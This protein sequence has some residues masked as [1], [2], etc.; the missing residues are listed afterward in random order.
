MPAHDRVT[1]K[2]ATLTHRRVL[3]F[4]LPITLSNVTVPLL[5]LVDTGVIGQLG[6]AAPIGAVGIG[7]AILS[8][9]FWVFGFLRMGT[10]G[11][12]AQAHGAGDMAEV[13]AMLTRGLLVA[14]VAGAALIVLQVPLIWAAFQIA[15][16]SDE[17]EG[18]ARSYLQIRIFGAPVAIGIYAMTGWLIALERTRAVLA[19]QLMTNTV[20][21][22][23]DLW[24][25]LGMDWGIEGVA[26][27]TLMAE[28]L[29]FA[30]GLFLCREV[31]A[32]PGWADPRRI[33][34]TVVLKHM[35]AVN[36]DILIRSLLLQ[37]IFI[38]FMFFGAKLSDVELAANQVLIQFVYVTAYALDGFALAAE[39]FVGQ[40]VGRRQVHVLRRASVMTSWW[41]AGVSLVLAMIFWLAGPWGI[42][43][44][45]TA[46]DVQSTAGTYLTYMVF[47]PL[48]GWPSF[49]L[50][51]IFI[52]ATRSREMRNMMA[53]SVVIYALS[54]AILFPLLGNHGLW[55]ALLISF[56]ARGAT[57]LWRYPVLERS[58]RPVA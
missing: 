2:P 1:L 38:S 41:A 51:G 9:L 6:Q 23:L 44:M 24:F 42:A 12:T 30:L 34:D 25:V 5:G 43:T 16:A 31:F 57:L 53:L 40:A 18:L 39:S 26:L 48:L 36:S 37:A 19:L 17:V 13:A 45:T 21:I 27:A 4:A 49:M 55:L 58:V 14:L 33:L 3:K 47:A 56:V 10:T 20:N 35:A 8:A 11:L 15:P 28:V 52:G 46:P 54:L 22:L 7:A 29:G 32:R 50:D